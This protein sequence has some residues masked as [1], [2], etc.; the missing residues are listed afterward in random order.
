MIENIEEGKRTHQIKI[1]KK[2]GKDN[3][4][5][6]APSL[7]L[8]FLFFFFSLSSELQDFTTTIDQTALH[9]EIQGTETKTLDEK[10]GFLCGVETWSSQACKRHIPLA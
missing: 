6:Q 8:F 3:N 5:R 2:G 4:Q 9:Q 10:P 1:K 7:F